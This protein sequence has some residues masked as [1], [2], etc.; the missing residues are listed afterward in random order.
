MK[1]IIKLLIVCFILL[2]YSPAQVSAQEVMH[3]D[4]LYENEEG[5]LYRVRIGDP[6]AYNVVYPD[7]YFYRWDYGDIVSEVLYM[8][9]VGF[10]YC[11]D[12]D[13]Y[14]PSVP[15]DFERVEIISDPATNSLL[16]HGFPHNAS[17]L[18]QKHN[19]S[20]IQAYVRTSIALKAVM[21]PDGF[22]YF[23]GKHFTLESIRAHNDP[24]I[25][26]I[27]DAAYAQ[28]MQSLS[29]GSKG[30]Y[31]GPY[32][33]EFIE[34]YHEL[35]YN[36]ERLTL[37]NSDRKLNNDNTIG[38]NESFYFAVNQLDEAFTERIT[39]VNNT[40]RKRGVIYDSHIPNIQRVAY[41]E[42]YEAPLEL[43]VEYTPV[44]SD[45]SLR[46]QMHQIRGDIHNRIDL[47]GFQFTLYNEVGEEQADYEIDGYHLKKVSVH[48]T[49][50]NGVI[51]F[52]I[53]DHHQY[54]VQETYAPIFAKLD[55]TLHRIDSTELI[56]TN[57][58]ASKT[59]EIQK[60]MS[61]DIDR[62]LDTFEFG[63][64][65]RVAQHES[66]IEIEGYHYKLIKSKMTDINGQ[67]TFSNLDMEAIYYVKELS[68]PSYALKNPDLI[69]VAQVEE[70]I[71]VEVINDVIL[72]DIILIKQDARSFERLENAW[73]NIID[74]TNSIV[75]TVVSDANG[76]VHLELLHGIDYSIQET[77]APRGYLL[78]ENIY[79]IQSLQLKSGHQDVIL[80][81]NYPIEHPKV[82]PETGQQPTFFKFLNTFK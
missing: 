68:A 69:E 56:V 14:A 17:Q 2:S 72:D 11:I 67:V 22:T 24:Y 44:T 75:D 47:S 20:D 51:H 78:D 28:D 41:L 73:F 10:V 42:R 61:Q 18:Q 52:E 29:L 8:R 55:P 23:T 79:T 59:I 15:T 63:L 3:F 80:I 40:I 62:P 38:S 32:S 31:L 77:Q 1:K 30:T 5:A 43:I 19:I 7:D 35:I 33:L 26:D 4:P 58:Y 9:G 21:Y 54:F 64:Y 65:R 57:E 82:L 25:N 50:A 36:E 37:H 13:R 45:I 16:A 60:R 66:D 34:D 76:M 49:D 70:F 6:T 74:D 12:A 46:K 27:I 71:Q 81:D 39:T 48:E 53:L